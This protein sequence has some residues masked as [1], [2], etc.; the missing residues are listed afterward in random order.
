MI[1]HEYKDISGKVVA[2]EYI[3]LETIKP[4][5]AIKNKNAYEISYIL[6]QFV[7]KGFCIFVMNSKV[8]RVTIFG[9][10][11]NADAETGVFCLPDHK[12]NVKFDENYLDLLRSNLRTYYLDSAHFIPEKMEL[13]KMKSIYLQFNR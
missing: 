11:P 13:K 12:L 4:D 2:E 6:P 3:Y 1:Y 8:I 7:V 10:H 9:L 5:R